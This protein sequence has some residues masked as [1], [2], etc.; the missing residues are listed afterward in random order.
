MTTPVVSIVMPV[1]EEG[2]AIVPCLDRMLGGVQLP[3]ELLAVFDHADDS[4][5]AHLEK[6][7]VADPRVKPVLNGHGKGDLFV[8]VQ[9]R[10]PK[11]I[12]KEQRHLL[13]Q[14]AKHLP[15]DDCE[16]RT[17]EEEQDERNLFDRVKDIFG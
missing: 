17:R 3:C 4:T 1:Y 7:A 9:A 10:T 6:Y 8:T 2:E 11:K 14:L 15:K 5:V 12:T 13:E 16:P